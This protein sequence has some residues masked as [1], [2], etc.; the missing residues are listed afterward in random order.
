M[1]KVSICIPTFNRVQLLPLAIE[2]VLQQT[3]PDWELLVC[4]DGS[5][6][7]TA[8]LMSQYTDPRIRYIRHPQN[9]GG[10]KVKE[11]SQQV[12]ISAVNLGG[13]VDRNLLWLFKCSSSFN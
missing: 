2:S 9:N 8:A 13:V 1:P 3:E 4:D 6:D 7:R 11:P 5:N 10:Q 12:V